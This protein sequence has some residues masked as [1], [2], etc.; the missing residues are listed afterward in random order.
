MEVLVLFLT[1]Y[2]CFVEFAVPVMSILS[3]SHE[4]AGDEFA[5]LVFELVDIVCFEK[6]VWFRVDMVSE[7]YH[8]CALSEPFGKI[9]FFH[10][11]IVGMLTS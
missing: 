10:S 7:T 4:L 2:E 3:I 6:Y 1:A 5:S 8:T 9:Q 11:D